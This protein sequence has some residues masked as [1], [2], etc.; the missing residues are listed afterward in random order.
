MTNQKETG[1]NLRNS[2]ADLPNIFLRLL[3]LIQ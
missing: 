3:T 1:W 2:Y